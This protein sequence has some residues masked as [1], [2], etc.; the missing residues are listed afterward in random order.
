MT[1]A[2]DSKERTHVVVDIGHRT[3]SRTRI[4]GQGFLADGDDRREAM[5][6]LNSRLFELRDEMPGER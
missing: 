3:Y 2:I 6:R 5:N 4:R 1:N